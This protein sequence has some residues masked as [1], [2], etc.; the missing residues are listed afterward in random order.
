MHASRRSSAAER[1]T[2]GSHCSPRFFSPRVPFVL[3]W[4]QQA[5][6]YTLLLALTLLATLLLLRALE[7]GSRR[8]WAAYG[9]ALAA[10]VVWHPVVGLLLI[11]SQVVLTFQGRSRLTRHALLAAVIVCVLGLPWAGQIAIRSTGERASINWL[12]APT[13]DVVAKAVLDVSGA[14]GLGVVLGAL[15]LILLLAS[16]RRASA[17][18]LAT[19]AI[20]A[21]RGVHRRFRRKADLPRPVSHGRCTCVRASLRRRDRRRR[22]AARASPRP[23][24]GSCE[25]HIHRAL[26][27]ARRGGQLAWRGLARRGRYRLES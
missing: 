14:S 6:G 25:R 24:C 22:A 13:A 8:R 3:K 1:S 20:G 23:L 19:W 12:D 21:V 5:R 16:G 2:A 17:A 27:L 7:R 4:A 15:G 9:L 11:P 26:V 18:W 10:V